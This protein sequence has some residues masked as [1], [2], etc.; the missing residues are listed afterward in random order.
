VFLFK[1]VNSLICLVLLD[2]VLL[3]RTLVLIERLLIVLE[4]LIP[5]SIIVLSR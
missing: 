3:I 4:S 1:E 5:S 2:L